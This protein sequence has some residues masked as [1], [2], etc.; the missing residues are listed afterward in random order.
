MYYF[1]AE[2]INV[3]INKHNFPAEFF[4][5]HLGNFRSDIPH[6]SRAY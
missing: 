4:V 5:L 3:Y 2:N 6:D 1:I